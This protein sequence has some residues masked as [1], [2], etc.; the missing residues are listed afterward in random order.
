MAFLRIQLR[1]LRLIGYDFRSAPSRAAVA[2]TWASLALVVLILW[3][4][5]CFVRANL[6]DMRLVTDGLAPLLCSLLS[7]AKLATFGLKRTEFGALVAQLQR[8]WQNS[9][10]A[11]I[12]S[13]SI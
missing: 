10:W 3:P 2:V 1:I 12:E 7:V 9:E 5:W 6:G 4:E 8:L 11:K 13:N